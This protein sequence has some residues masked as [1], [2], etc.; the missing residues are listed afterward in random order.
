MRVPILSNVLD[1]YALT[2][3]APLLSPNLQCYVD[4]SIPR[5][6]INAPL[7]FK[8]TPV[9]YQQLVDKYTGWVYACT[10][11]NSTTVAEVPLRLYAVE[12]QGG[13]RAKAQFKKVDKQRQNYFRGKSHFSSTLAMGDEI[14]EITDHPW[15]DLLRKVND[16][17]NGFEMIELMEL[18]LELTGNAYWLIE[19]GP[20]GLPSQIWPLPTQHIEIVKDKNRFISHYLYGV[21]K[22]NRERFEVE[23]VVHFRFP[24]PNNLFYGVGPMEAARLSA[25]LNIKF[26][27]FEH[28]L[29]DNGAVMPFVVSTGEDMSKENKERLRADIRKK[30]GGFKRAGKFGIFGPGAKILPLAASP[31]DINYSIGHKLTKEKIA[32]IF[33]VPL[34]LLT[35]EDVNRSNAETGMS[36]YMRTTI[37]PR[38]NRIEQT[39][40]QD[41]IQK[42][43]DTKLFVAFDDPVPEDR[44][45]ALEQQTA[46]LKTQ[47]ITINEVRTARGMEEVEWGHKPQVGQGIHTLGEEPLAF[48]RVPREII[49][50]EDEP[51]GEEEQ[52]TH[53]LP[54]VTKV[55]PTEAHEILV[56]NVRQWINTTAIIAASY[57]TE[58]I[59]LN[60]GAL[61]A[62]IPWSQIRENGVELMEPALKTTL[63]KG[64]TVG[65]TRMHRLG[66]TASWNIQNPHAVEWARE[67]VGRRITVIT[68]Q[69]RSVIRTAVADHIRSGLTV[70]QLQSDIKQ[71]VGLNQPQAKALATFKLKLRE[72]GELS[73][74]AVNAAG[75]EYHGRLKKQRAEMIARTETAAAFA[76]GNVKSYAENGITKKEYSAA[77]DACPI[78]SPHDGRVFELADNELS[79]P[80]HPSCRCDWLPVVE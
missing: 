5:F 24:N 67:F 36:A 68:E 60:H 17:Y 1:R 10:S 34:S 69:T 41:I 74:G 46:E 23:Q 35:T 55:Q 32:A 73:E 14:V 33:G 16:F 57:V 44:K 12:P 7:F 56:G 71:M 15:L 58:V 78:C 22:D 47:V 29:L 28:A 19:K 43:Y 66:M 52:T 38:L 70:P 8:Q 25:D 6:E 42:F 4:S 65:V 40:N 39:L 18:F 3:A 50:I 49:Q 30:H 79:I 20:N 31:K 9:D 75:S 80:L 11:K 26:D 27:E 64:A 45:F 76:E 37:K 13:L 63:N 77:G 53:L 59:V 62:L 61:D 48:P 51:E 54:A 21:E 72:T 2:R